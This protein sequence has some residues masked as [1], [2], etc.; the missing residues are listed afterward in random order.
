MH[1]R[2]DEQFSKGLARL[3]FSGLRSRLLL[4]LLLALLPVYGFILY[5]T[6]ML[7]TPLSHRGASL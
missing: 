1:T 4:P 7:T 5:S 3:P 6:L 2:F